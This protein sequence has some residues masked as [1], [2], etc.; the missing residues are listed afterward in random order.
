MRLLSGADRTGRPPV[1]DE[2]DPVR[3]PPA[4]P[5]PD[6]ERH[7]LVRRVRMAAGGQETEAGAHCR[8]RAAAQPALLTPWLWHDG[9]RLEL[10]PETLMLR[11]SLYFVALCAL[12]IV[13]AIVAGGRW[14]FDLVSLRF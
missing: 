9:L 2:A 1:A 8:T 13:L 10:K 11:S 5:D 3:M 7:R 12:W 6:E 14:I 4:S